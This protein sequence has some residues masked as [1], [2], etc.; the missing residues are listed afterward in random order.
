[1]SSTQP[2][3]RSQF[4][5]ISQAIYQVLMRLEEAVAVKFVIHCVILSMQQ[6][7]YNIFVWAYYLLLLVFSVDAV[8]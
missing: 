2:S 3:L 6:N 4:K 1:M 5:K 8:C 7:V